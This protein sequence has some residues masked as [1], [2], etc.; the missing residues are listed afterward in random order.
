MIEG[1]SVLCIGG[2]KVLGQSPNVRIVAQ[3][4]FVFDVF[5]YVRQNHVRFFSWA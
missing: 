2:L 1:A 4:S 5:F 3:N